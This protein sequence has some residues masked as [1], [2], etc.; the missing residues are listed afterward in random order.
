[1]KEGNWVSDEKLLSSM[2]RV[3]RHEKGRNST[4]F[5]RELLETSKC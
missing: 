3:T 4:P 1:M 2:I 5:E